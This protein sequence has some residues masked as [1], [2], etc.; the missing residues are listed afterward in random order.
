MKTWTQHELADQLSALGL[1]GKVAGIHSKLSAVGEIAPSPVTPEEEKKGMRPFAKTLINAF[2]EALGPKGTLF[3]PSH[4]LNTI[5]NF[6]AAKARTEE[7][8][9]LDDGYYNP[10]KSPSTVGSFSQS[11]VADERAVRSLHPTHST[12]SIGPEAEYL[13]R[14]HTPR[15]QPVGIYSA[16]AKSVGLDGLILFV[17][18][19]LNTNTMFHAYETL[20][21]PKLAPYFPGAA[22]ADYRGF[23]RF[24]MQEWVPHLHRDFY[25]QQKR[26]TRAFARMREA[27]LL[28]QAKLGDG[29]LNYY[30]AKE[31]ARFFAE[32]VFPDEPDIL[33]CKDASTC[34]LLQDC[35]QVERILKY[36][37]GK[38]DGWD[39]AK[40]KSNMSREFLNL[41]KPGMR[42]L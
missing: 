28:H 16:F 41:I 24:F 3:V 10:E 35:M 37:Y 9:V 14:H 38:K 15:A 25:A 34:S 22:A 4:S 29:P 11:V 20:L 19:V 40:I 5:G 36:L 7:G 26:E 33:F 1:K 13:A 21:L 31:A 17:G 32:E 12:A 27:G 42:R 2:L 8:K 18:D 39:S 6:N 30:H 23:K